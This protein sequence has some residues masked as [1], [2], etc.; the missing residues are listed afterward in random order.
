MVWYSHLFQNFPQFIVIHTVKGFGI[1]LINRGV[2]S[3][4]L[5]VCLLKAPFC[6]GLFLFSP[7]VCWHLEVF[8]T[9]CVNSLYCRVINTLPDTLLQMFFLDYFYFSY[10]VPFL[11]SFCTFIFLNLVLCVCVCVI[12]TFTSMKLQKL[13]LPSKN[14]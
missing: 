3:V 10:L 6:M 14:R 8:R 7:F 9:I 5:H 4:S 13:S 12:C 11:Q 2:W 1:H